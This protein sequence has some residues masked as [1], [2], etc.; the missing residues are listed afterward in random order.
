MQITKDTL[1]QLYGRYSMHKDVARQELKDHLV[2]VDEYLVDSIA[3][4]SFLKELWS[5]LKELDQ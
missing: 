1:L 4:Q 2:E 5:K 3:K